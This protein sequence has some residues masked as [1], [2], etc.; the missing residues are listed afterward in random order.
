ML[1]CKSRLL[2][3]VLPPPHAT[4]FHVAESRRSFYF[5]EHENLFRAEV[6]IRATNNRN[7]QCNIVA[8]HCCATSCKKKCCPY[9]LTLRSPPTRK[10]CGKNADMFCPRCFPFA[11]TGNICCGNLF[12]LPKNNTN[13]VSDSSRKQFSSAPNVF[14]LAR[15]K[16][17]QKRQRATSTCLG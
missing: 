10:L 11:C 13:K 7:L 4:N 12:W 3:P 16:E 9:Y 14:P 8:R 17:K 15:S 2:L 1:H 6:V 5:L